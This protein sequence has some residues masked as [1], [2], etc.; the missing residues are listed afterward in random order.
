MRIAM[1]TKRP[2]IADKT[3]NLKI[4]EDSIN[5]TTADIYIFGELFLSGYH[6]KDELRN[7]AEPLNG[8]SITTLKKIAKEKNCFIVFIILSSSKS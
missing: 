4:M 3:A 6:C 8:P 1:I 2:K 7:L 5:E